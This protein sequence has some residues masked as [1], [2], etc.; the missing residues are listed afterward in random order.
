M[1]FGIIGGS[2]FNPTSGPRASIL[3]DTDA[4]TPTYNEG[5]LY[6]DNTDHT[7]AIQTEV[8]GVT[9]QVGQEQFVRVL[10]KTGSTIADGSVVYINGSQGQRPTIAKAIATS[11]LADK[12]IGLV[13]YDIADNAEGYVTVNGLVRGQ[14]T[15]SWNEGDELFISATTAGALTNVAPTAPNHAIRIGIVSYKNPSHGVILVAIQTGTSL[16]DLHDVKLTSV[17]TGD[18]LRWDGTLGYWKNVTTGVW[19]DGSYANPSWVTSLAGSKLTGGYTASGMTMATARLLGR[20]TASTG[21]AEEISI[22][23]GLSLSAGTLSSSAAVSSVGATGSDGISVSG[24][25]ITTSGVLAFSLTDNGVQNAKLAS[26]AANT[27]KGNNTGVTANVK[28]LTATE[29]ATMLPLTTTGAKGMCP[30]LPSSGGTGV[31][32]R[33]DG[34]WQAVAGSGTVTSVNVSGG[35]TGLTFSGGPITASG[36]VTM[37]G[38]LAIANGGTGS[39]T[40]AAART[41][42]GVAGLA[43]ANT[44]SQ[45]QVIGTDPGG[46]EK[47]RIGGGVRAN[48]TL[49]VDVGSASLPASFKGGAGTNIAVNA[50]AGGGNEWRLGDAIGASNGQLILYDYTNSRRAFLYS[51][52]AG[53]EF[54][55]AGAT[56]LSIDTSQNA[57]FAGDV[58]LAT[59]TPASASAAGVTGT[60]AWDSSYIYICTATNTWKRVAIATW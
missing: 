34:S 24:S 36:T 2:T 51:N 48:G 25:P 50:T 57:T 42:L 15:N 29:V 49:V 32:L 9:L 46:S 47:L 14:N 37:A 10:N 11:P 28:D 1:S 54:R 7:L 35:S 60:I 5:T 53:W 12:V 8:N 13:T 40:A 52:A 58:R 33:G 20:S 31:Y 3:F 4:G 45:A 59:K 38:T 18:A 39:G 55:T 30:Q 44:F 27:I 19:T 56:A 16:A 6:W 23:A 22:G 43:D 21:A 41:A 26:M 17:A